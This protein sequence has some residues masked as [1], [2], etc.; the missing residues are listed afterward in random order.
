MT[1]TDARAPG[2]HRLP[3]KPVL[4]ILDF[5]WTAASEGSSKLELAPTILRLLVPIFC[6]PDYVTC[7]LGQIQNVY[8]G[9]I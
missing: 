6:G 5:Y 9:Q 7:S 3:V 1:T 2:K 8:N 4:N